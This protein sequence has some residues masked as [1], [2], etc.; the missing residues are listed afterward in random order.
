M[1]LSAALSTKSSLAGSLTLSIYIQLVCTGRQGRPRHCKFPRHGRNCYMYIH[2]SC[3]SHREAHRDT[4]FLC[5]NIT[6]SDS[7]TFFKT[8]FSIFFVQSFQLNCVF[9]KWD[10][11]RFLF[12]CLFLFCLS[13]LFE[14]FC[15][16]W[17]VENYIL[18]PPRSKYIL[19]DATL[20]D[21][22]LVQTYFYTY[23]S[24]KPPYESFKSFK[25]FLRVVLFF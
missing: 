19:L 8:W 12:F 20:G 5:R 25:P 3:F 17:L 16:W 4:V 21:V 13:S 1:G 11:N 15:Q 24:E 6:S 18:S 23:A 2:P 7:M 22:T 10:E 9:I 14:Y